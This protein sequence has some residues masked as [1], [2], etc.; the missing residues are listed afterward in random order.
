MK[1]FGLMIVVS[2]FCSAAN[3]ANIEVDSGI[4]VLIVNGVKTL[5]TSMEEELRDGENQIVLKMDARLRNDGKTEY[6][7]SNPYIV[8]FSYDSGSDLE[9]EL[10][11]KSVEETQKLIAS[12]AEF[13]TIVQNEQDKITSWAELPAADSYLPYIDPL[14]NLIAYN[15][16]NGFIFDGKNIRSLKQ[17]LAN[18]SD[19]PVTIGSGQQAIR[20]TE[21]T[22]Q[23]KLW[24][25][26]AN[27]EER[28]QFLRWMDEQK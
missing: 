25:T 24:Y 6:V 4:E 26:R 15:K 12:E 10:K 28:E 7:T 18:I 23:L 13:V 27:K 5:G 3:A 1:K 22:L 14:K 17:E 21:N 11:S 20:E 9:L 19:A 16:E 8:T 2:L